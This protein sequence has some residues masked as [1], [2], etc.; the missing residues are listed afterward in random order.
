MPTSRPRRT[1]AQRTNETRA[2]LLDATLDTLVE[3]GYKATTTTAVA[4]RAGVSLGAV[5]HH[6][7]TKTD[8]LVA[9]IGHACDRR[10]AEFREAIAQVDAATDRLDAAIDL[11]WSIFSGPTY[12]AFVELWI[13]ART[14]PELAGPLVTVDKEFARVS[15]ELHSELF[16]AAV[17]E[18]GEAARVGMHLT[19]ALLSGLAMTQMI[20]G[21]R[22]H[23]AA[24]VLAAHRTMIRATLA[25]ARDVH[26]EEGA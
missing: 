11:L 7:P 10:T 12:T 18:R 23:D 4:H 9:A 22:P 1:Q 8:L 20:D 13:A 16:P 25:A 26:T 2:A 14:D 15:E 19:F 24:S 17:A 21:Y 5:L 6:F 3:S